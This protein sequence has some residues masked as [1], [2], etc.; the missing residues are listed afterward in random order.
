MWRWTCILEQRIGAG[1]RLSHRAHRRHLSTDL[2]VEVHDGVLAVD[3]P[4]DRWYRFQARHLH[5]VDGGFVADPDRRRRPVPAQPGASRSSGWRAP[6]TPSARAAPC[7][8]SSPMARR[9]C[10]ARRRPFI[11]MRERIERHVTQRTE[12]LAG[13]SHDLKTPLTRLKLALAMMPTRD[14]RNSAADAATMIAE[15]EHMLDEY[16]AFARGEGGEDCAISGSGRTGAGSR[17]RGRQGAAARRHADR[18]RAVRT[19]RSAVKRAALR[20]CCHQPDR[21]RAQAR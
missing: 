2:R 11:T 20:R 16:L 5:P 14:A 19:S 8:T 9:K 10:A 7:R 13:V 4:R 3:V 18:D 15:M 21:Q 1:S 6:P 12:M 17:R